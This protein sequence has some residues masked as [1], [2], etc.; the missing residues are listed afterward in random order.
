LKN[1]VSQIITASEAEMIFHWYAYHA[2]TVLLGFISVLLFGY[3]F[4]HRQKNGTWYSL[5]ILSLVLLWSVAQGLEFSVRDLSDK[6]I[7]ANV[8]YM[9][10]T[11]IPVLYF[12]LSV[13]HSKIEFI[14]KNKFLP[15]LLLLLPVILNILIWTDPWHGLIRQ[16]VRISMDGIVPTIVKRFGMTMLPFAVYNFTL[17]FA[18]LAILLI[19][20]MDKHFQYKDQAKYLFIGLLVPASTTLLHFIGIGFYNIDLTPSSFAVTGIL[21]TFGIFRH[22][23]F[24]IVPIALSHVVNDMKPGLI[25]YDNS[26]RLI[27][28]NPSAKRI[29]HLGGQRAA[30]LPA[31]VAFAHV[32]DLLKIMEQ[33]LGCKSELSICSDC[34]DGSFEV[35]VTHLENGKGKGLGWMAQIYDIT[36]R[37]AEEEKLKQDRENAMRL[38]KTA[39]ETSIS[40]ESAF[41]QA[42][43]KPHFLFNALNVIAVL[44]RMDSEKARELIL[45]L[46]SYMRHSFDF[47]NLVKYIAFEDELEFI[48]AYVRI[49][50]A[51]FKDRLNVTYEIDDTEGLMLP[52]LLLQPLVEN[53][54]RHGIRKNE[55][56]RTVALVVKNQEEHYL[57]EV[58]DDG[59]G[60]T[61]EQ[62]EAIRMEQAGDGVG[63]ANIQKR[64][65]MLYGTQLFI[66]SRQGMGT[67]I[68]MKLPKRKEDVI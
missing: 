60:M 38:Y 18:T 45:D 19:T 49:E 30:G 44:C 62:L 6:L 26:L 16:D 23:L 34:S 43:M 21:L 57:I 66:E 10:I 13:S 12:Y 27:D 17:T 33:R 1:E 11:I 68:T 64:L 36:E 59:A 41:L 24:D 22:G 31:S 51:R 14:L 7:F 29:L 47:K 58:E 53:A 52:P 65:R 46:S 39:E 56:G 8:Q 63:L 37:K 42:Q 48:Q 20:W 50:Q 25:V 40:N 67:K 61:P 2:L 35:T 9:P 28:I 5:G 32:P 15:F 3:V 54:I 4:I 55:T